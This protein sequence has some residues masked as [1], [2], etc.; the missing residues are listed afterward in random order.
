M[1]NQVAIGLVLLIVA[2]LGANFWLGLDAHIFLGKKFVDFIEW[3][4]FW[5]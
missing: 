2:A 5:R 4:A 1:T 3:L